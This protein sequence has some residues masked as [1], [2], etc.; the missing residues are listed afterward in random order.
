MKISIR[1]LCVDVPP[2]KSRGELELP[3]GASI[4]AALERCVMEYGLEIS[5]D[6]LKKS[7]FLINKSAVAADSVLNDGDLLTVMRTLAGG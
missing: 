5:A 4:G 6:E 3:D 7:M 2:D 1:F